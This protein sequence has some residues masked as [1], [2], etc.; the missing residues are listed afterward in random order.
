MSDFSLAPRRRPLWRLFIMPVLLLV[1]AAAWSGFWFYAAS[2]VGVRAD[3]WAAQEAK[4][5]R[6]YECGKRSVA[7]YPFRLEVRCDDASVSLVSQTAAAG[8]PIT[9]RLGEILVI[10]QIYQ[11]KLLIAEF[12]APATLS[13]R[14]QP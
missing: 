14:G 8:A 13:D 7:G 11:P 12:K 5:G 10:A 9:V 1:A 2:E 6:V 3:A 4:S